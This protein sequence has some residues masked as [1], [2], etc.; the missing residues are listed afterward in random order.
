MINSDPVSSYV[1]GI[2]VD[3]RIKSP[4]LTSNNKILEPAECLL[5]QRMFFIP[6]HQPLAQL[7]YRLALAEAPQR[8]LRCPLKIG[9]GSDEAKKSFAFLA[10][11][12]ISSAVHVRTISRRSEVCEKHASHAIRRRQWMAYRPLKHG[13]QISMERVHHPEAISHENPILVISSGDVTPLIE[14]V[15]HCHD[16]LGADQS[17]FKRCHSPRIATEGSSTA[18]HSSP[19]HRAF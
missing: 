19:S 2:D 3:E 1:N 9:S 11:R 13:L 14:E 12:V 18:V 8:V 6:I 16:H 15:M 10:W 5:S 17:I 4:N 7:P